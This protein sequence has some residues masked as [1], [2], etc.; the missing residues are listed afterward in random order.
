MKVFQE[1]EL[2]PAIGK[3]KVKPDAI[4]KS[5]KPNDL[6]RCC[7]IIGGEELDEIYIK[8]TKKAIQ[9]TITL[10]KNPLSERFRANMTAIEDIRPVRAMDKISKVLAQASME[11]NFNYVKDKIK[12]KIF[13]FDNEFDDSQIMG[14]ILEKLDFLGYGENYKVITYGDSIN[15]EA[16]ME[17]IEEVMEKYSS[18]TKIW[19]LSLGIESKICDGSM[20]DLGIYLDYVQDTYKVQMFV[21]SGNLNRLPLRE[22]PPQEDMGEADR[23][24]SPADSVRAITV[25]S[26]ALYES[27]DSMVKRNEPSPFS[28]RG[29]GANYIVKPDVVDYG[30][31]ISRKLDITGLGMKGLDTFGNL[32][33][34]NG[35]SYSTPRV[36]QKFAAVYDEMADK[37]LLLAK[38]MIIHSA[39]MNARELLDQNQDNK[40]YY[41]FGMPSV[42]D[43]DILQCSEDEVTLVFKQK[44]FPHTHL[45]MLDFP[46]PSSLIR[47]GKCFGEIGMTLVYSPVLDERFGREYCRTNIDVSFGIYK[48]GADG[49][50]NYKGQVPLEDAWDAKFERSRVENGFKWSPVKSY[51]RRISNKGLNMGEG[52]KIRIDMNPRNGLADLPQ[53]FVLILTIRDPNGNDIYSEVINGLRE[54]GYMTNNLE[55]RQQLRQRR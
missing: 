13:D 30:G 11:G 41:G 10:I 4:A 44:V 31:N 2:I 8:V 32:I 49:E 7:P 27:T 20:S 38:A 50:I 6:C 21:S 34:G 40:K 48:Y 29:P 46:Y 45:E 47:N 25:G 39:R 24:I 51:Y 17:I 16:L 18:T 52:W 15:E 43:S 23:I 37:D 42:D 36:M 26:I 35:T 14:Y 19:N 53:D 28:R 1:N 5:H 3:I 22:W 12:V 55:T 33:E 54:R 9:E